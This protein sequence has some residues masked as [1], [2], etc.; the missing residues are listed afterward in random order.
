MIYD[1]QMMHSQSKDCR[2]INNY[3]GRSEKAF[4]A[5]RLKMNIQ[6]AKVILCND[7]PVTVTGHVLENIAE[8]VH[9]GHGMKKGKDRLTG[10][11]FGKLKLILMTAP[12]PISLKQKVYTNVIFRSQQTTLKIIAVIERNLE[13]YAVRDRAE[14][15]RNKPVQ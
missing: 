9:L 8:F 13:S 14:H 7:N 11:A 2:R 10:P 5:V 6:K 4:A 15:A 12:I 1:L 3:A